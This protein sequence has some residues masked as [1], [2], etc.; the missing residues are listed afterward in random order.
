MPV[1][2]QCIA[3]ALQYLFPEQLEFTSIFRDTAKVMA[4]LEAEELR[5]SGNIYKDATFLG[6]FLNA[7]IYRLLN[8]QPALPTN[9]IIEACRLGLLCFLAEIRRRFG[10]CCLSSRIHVRKLRVALDMTSIEWTAL[11]TLRLWIV[12]MGVLEATKEPELS[13]MELEWKCLSLAQKLGMPNLVKALKSIMW[14]ESIH[15]RRLRE[16]GE[17][18][19]GQN[20]A[21]HFTR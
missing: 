13:W 20:I 1:G 4:H 14:F 9:S 5:T 17:R 2:A 11:D 16:L 21:N 19:W 18:F 12:T 6:R 7:L 8:C 15:G 3:N 10:L